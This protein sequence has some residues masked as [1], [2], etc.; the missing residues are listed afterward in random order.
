[1]RLQENKLPQENPVLDIPLFLAERMYLETVVRGSIL[2]IL[3]ENADRLTDAFLQKKH[4]E[5]T[6][7][8]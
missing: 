7:S 4:L 6:I 8:R 5:P 3:R 1:M 2:H